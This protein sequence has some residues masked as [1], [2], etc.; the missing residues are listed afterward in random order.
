MAK[1][2]M[3]YKAAGVDID[4]ADKLIRQLAPLIHSTN[5]PGTVGKIGGFGGLFA[6]P[7]RGMKRPLLVSGTDGVGTKL[8]VAQAVG[9]HDTVGIDLVAMC[10]NDIVC[11]GAE[12]LFFLDYFAT[13]GI[14]D[15]VYRDVLK[16]VVNG[17]KQAGCVLLGGETAEMPGLYKRGDYDLA[18]FAVGV[19]DEPKVV[20]G[21]RIK[22]GDAVIGLKSSGLH[23]NGFS[24]AR[25]VFTRKELAGPW[26]RKLLKPT[27]IYVKPLLKLMAAVDVLGVANITGGGFYDNIPR[28]LPKGVGVRIDRKAWRVPPIF[29]EVQRRGRVDEHEMFRT[30]NMGIGMVVVVR[31]A[32]ADKARRLLEAAKVK[33][34]L[35]GEITKGDGAVVL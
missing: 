3:T 10:V 18:G 2:A 30:L 1:K 17:C 26:G 22:P 23:S 6:A 25:K 4:K 12:P 21:R 28:C 31:A 20:D 5:R 7:T 34:C 29:S 13:G 33:T 9:R 14:E 16:G 24:L 32:Q 11:S 8:L 27:I 19:V 15:R 35:L